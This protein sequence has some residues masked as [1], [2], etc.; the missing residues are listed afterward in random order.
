MSDIPHY[1]DQPATLDPRTE[2]PE[3]AEQVP[4]AMGHDTEA[5]AAEVADAAQVHTENVQAE[6]EARDDALSAGEPEPGAPG[7]PTQRLDPETG[8]AIDSDD[9][10]VPDGTID[11]VL[12]WVG[13]DPSRASRALTVERAGQNRTTLVSKLEAI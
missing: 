5:K 6:T 12:N 7:D 10:E 3:D 13:D 11:D 8:E 1:H 2:I 4:R 9:E